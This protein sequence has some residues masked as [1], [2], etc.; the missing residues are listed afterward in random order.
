MQT[1]GVFAREVVLREALVLKVSTEDRA[2]LETLARYA[3]ARP[4]FRALT[5]VKYGDGGVESATFEI[6]HHDDGPIVR[7][8]ADGPSEFE[9]PV[10]DDAA[11]LV[12]EADV[13]ASSNG[14]HDDGAA[15]D[16]RR[17]R[18]I[19]FRRCPGAGGLSHT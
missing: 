7:R 10:A 6:L 16:R 11:V 17:D 9:V 1:A 12:D 14:G 13:E 2:V 19:P 5:T 3:F 18:A 8:L 15:T 4:G